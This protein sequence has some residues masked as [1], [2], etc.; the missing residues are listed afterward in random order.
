MP[1]SDAGVT[2]EPGDCQ[3]ASGGHA[4]GDTIVT[5]E[6]DHDADETTD[7]D[8][9]TDNDPD[10]D[11]DTEQIDVSTFEYV[12]GSM[13]GDSLAGDHRMPTIFTGGGGDDVPQG[14]RRSGPRR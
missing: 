14:R 1:S 12:T 3:S 7:S 6:V 8:D 4:D 9:P 10:D 2:C 11:P 5:F 13:H